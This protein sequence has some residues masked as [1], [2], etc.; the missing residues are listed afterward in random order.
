MK[1][2]NRIN[3]LYKIGK[4]LV[5]NERNF[6]KKYIKLY[7]GQKTISK[8]H[9]LLRHAFN[10]LDYA[11]NENNEINPKE[12]LQEGRKEK[13]KF[14]IYNFEEALKPEKSKKM[15]STDDELLK[16]L[17]LKIHRKNLEEQLKKSEEMKT[18]QSLSLKGIRRINT[19]FEKTFNTAKSVKS[20]N[21]LSGFSNNK[22]ND[23]SFINFNTSS[24]ILKTK[25]ISSYNNSSTKRFGKY[26]PPI[27]FYYYNLNDRLKSIFQNINTEEKYILTKSDFMKT[28]FKK[29]FNISK[30]NN[31]KTINTER[32]IK[33]KFI[34]K[35]PGKI[36]KKKD[37]ENILFK[38]SELAFNKVKNKIYAIYK[39]PKIQLRINHI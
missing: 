5:D 6:N 33:P 37:L 14:N 29:T 12:Y 23:S 20:Y 28:N 26:E 35:N 38:D 7:D 15:F 30:S 2:N 39:S 17:L 27:K 13:Y 4:R 10:I 21:N 31:M 3:N 24:K 36:K 25:N 32:I 8:D 18:L 19:N 1:F 22:S 9:Y 34:I 11:K 16:T